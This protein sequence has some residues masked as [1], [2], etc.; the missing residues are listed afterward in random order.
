MIQA[1]THQDLERQYFSN[2]ASQA[3]GRAVSFGAN[4]ISF[5]MIGHF[6]GIEF[7]GKYSYVLAF[8]G[9]FGAIADSGMCS[10]LGKGIAQ[11]DRSASLYWGNFLILK[12]AL[13]LAVIPVGVIAAFYVR[14]DLF[15]V[16]L[17]GLLAVPFIA[18]RFFD[19]I[20]Q[21]YRRPWHSTYSSL[22]YGVSYFL[23]FTAALIWTQSLALIVT[24]FIAANALYG[25]TAFLL[26]RRSLKPGFALNL[27]I[28]KG[29]VKLTAPLGV[30]S[31]FVIIT[32]R[33]PILML[34]AMKSDHAVAIFN[35]AYRFV[36]LSIL[37]ST[38]L[39][40]PLI[41]VFAARAIKG[42]D[43]LKKMFVPLIEFVAIVAL[44]VAVIVP[45][46]S[47]PLVSA[48]FG[49]AFVDS[50]PVLNV[51]AWDCVVLFYSLF[52]SAAALAI[53]AVRYAYWSGAGAALLCLGLNYFLIPR[54]SFLGTAWVVLVCEVFLAGVTFCYVMSHLGNVFRWERWAKIIGLNLLL[55]ILSNVVLA[56][57]GPFL[58][59]GVSMGVYV[60]LVLI[61]RITPT[62]L[63][64][65][66]TEKNGKNGDAG[67]ACGVGCPVL[68]HSQTISEG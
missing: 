54:W 46:F 40:A 60:I 16:L 35:A 42:K 57:F 6:A 11:A 38:A 31:L 61:S 19:P 59:V 36:E 24:A 64:L 22:V 12:V 56:G 44:P 9:V 53:G 52:S 68:P 23:L 20:F 47:G 5:V 7:F 8:L 37:L 58:R 65:F 3:V 41:P 55:Y 28:L 26:A 30:S 10:V 25:V 49:R 1:V 45:A 18:S 43:L 67:L 2:L 63:L 62:N 34:A 17:I 66:F 21:V 15:P 27:P 29:I 48:L 32:G 13:S 39:S 14:R 33:I 50:A 4:F 51:L